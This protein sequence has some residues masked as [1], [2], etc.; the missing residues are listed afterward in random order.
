V[1]AGRIRRFAE[2]VA[3]GHSFGIGPGTHDEPW[4]IDFQRQAVAIYAKALPWEYLTGLAASFED[5]ANLMVTVA[6]PKT[7]AVEWGRMQQYLRSAATAINEQ[8]PTTK[9]AESMTAADI[10]PITPPV[11]PFHLLAEAISTNE[12][13]D[14]RETGAT[15]E[16]CAGG[17]DECPLTDQEIDWIRRM[18]N[19]D[20]VIDIATAS[21]YSERA[22]YRALNELWDRLGVDNRNEAIALVG[23]YGWI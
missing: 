19:G 1:A 16:G 22:L 21:G 6:G 12:I 4:T 14:L 8:A 11:M 18:I 20:R 17:L 5:C 15:I 23:K 10:A 3:Q 7:A 13:A 9:P 2:A